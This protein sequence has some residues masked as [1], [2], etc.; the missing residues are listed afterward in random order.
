MEYPL[1]HL[2]NMCHAM[3][4]KIGIAA[5]MSIMANHVFAKNAPE[6]GL[7]Y[8]I[9]TEKPEQTILHFGASDAWSMQF[10]G[11]WPEKTQRQI[12]D[13][14]FSL[15]TDKKG[16][17]LGIGLSIWRFNLGAG[18][19]E[20]GD[21][22]EINYTTRTE[23]FMQH[24]GSYDWNKQ[25]GQRR[26]LQL[27]KERGVTHFLAFMNS[28]PVY[29]TDNGLATN[30]R[31]RR[32]MNI[33]NDAYGKAASF[34]ANV[35][36]GVEQHDGIH[37]D[38]FCPVNEP[39]WEWQGPKQEGS[40]ATNQEVAKLAQAIG[41]AFEANEISTKIM[42]NESADMRFLLGTHGDGIKRGNN[43]ACFFNPKN[44]DTYIGNVANVPKT[45]VGHSYWSNT[46]VDT[47]RA[48]RKALREKCRQY[49]ISFWQTE[50]C[51]MSN[52]DEIG[53]GPHFDT[54]MKTA[55]YVARIIHNDLVFANA[56][57]WS[58]WRA[59]GGDYKD[60]LIRVFTDERWT[61]GEAVDSKLLWSMG[62][63]SRFIRPGAVRHDITAYD[64]KGNIIED[65]DTDQYGI[66]CSAY[67]N[68]DGRWVVVAINYSEEERPF[69]FELSNKGKRRW[70]HY[71][72]SDKEGENLL[73]LKTAKGEVTLAAR[74]VNTF[75]SY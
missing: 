68:K 49:G 15:D 2:C 33:R 27:A 10:V 73:P 21:S 60:G 58:W 62:N 8:T 70:H 45:I 37:F 20:Q 65:G 56:E 69:C 7:S 22:S 53:G 13:W 40:P 59:V 41:K 48:V 44:T 26:F 64:A 23:C 46:P 3:M 31:R 32:N 38:Y 75:V 28:L 36:K 34:A 63:F 51:I 61:D 42:V 52:D 25:V 6:G 74:S 43:I 1:P 47:M 35:M 67:R 55:L 29:F 24:D 30:N 14:L 19:R 66:L 5:F 71:R 57:S 50:T 16:Q 12:A 17:P 72:T 54:T 9:E 11:L 18:S 39:E 4:L